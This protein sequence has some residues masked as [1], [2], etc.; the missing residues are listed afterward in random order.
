MHTSKSYTLPFIASQTTNDSRLIQ[1]RP[2][3]KAAF[4]EIT[5]T[6]V[7]R[8][9]E[10]QRIVGD[11]LNAEISEKQAR[12]IKYQLK[13]PASRPPAGTMTVPLDS[14]NS[15]RCL[16]LRL[17]GDLHHVIS[18]G[19]SGPKDL[20]RH[21]CRQSRAPLKLALR[22]PFGVSQIDTSGCWVKPPSFGG[23]FVHDN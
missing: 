6:A 4:D 22:S 19:L 23:C 2:L 13:A 16:S 1:R 9:H 11:L 3:P 20:V 14:F 12:S 18:M 17:F 7:K 10:P 21:S 8:Q 5:A 15:T